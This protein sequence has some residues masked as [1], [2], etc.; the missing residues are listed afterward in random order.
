M[1][2]RLLLSTLPALPILAV[3]GCTVSSGL[4]LSTQTAGDVVNVAAGV[5]SVM[6]L[7]AQSS[8]MAPEIVAKVANLVAKVRAAAATIVPGMLRAVAV[9]SVLTISQSVD[10]LITLLAGLPSV[11]EKVLQVLRATQT[12]LPLVEAAVGVSFSSA[13]R[14]PTQT[15]PDQARS[16][17]NTA[18]AP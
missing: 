3:A 11:P 10:D 4:T 15:T 6:V 14:V 9:P 13:A 8:G 12:I 1:L 18:A 7:I 16:V 5:S 17:L 2:R